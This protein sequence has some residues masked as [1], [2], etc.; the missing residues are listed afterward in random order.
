MCRDLLEVITQRDPNEKI[1]D[2][3]CVHSILMLAKALN[4]K[5]LLSNA[6]DEKYIAQATQDKKLIIW[7]VESE[8][9]KFEI[10]LA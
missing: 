10:A 2:P 4:N 7:D 3:M 5:E 6:A 9:I 1:E 8:T